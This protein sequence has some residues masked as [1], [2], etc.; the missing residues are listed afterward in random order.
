MKNNRLIDQDLM[1]LFNELIKNEVETEILKIFYSE[2]SEEAVL[3]KLI[4]YLE[5]DDAQV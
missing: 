4:A 3:E 1:D 5:S 2:E